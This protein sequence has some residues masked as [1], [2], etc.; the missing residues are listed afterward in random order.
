MPHIGQAGFDIVSYF[1]KFATKQMKGQMS[2]IPK[3]VITEC[4]RAHRVLWTLD[5]ANHLG[6]SA[7][8][9]NIRTISDL[10]SI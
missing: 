1:K 8:S 6:W 4:S 3:V 10:N 2:H 5:E 7:K 9:F